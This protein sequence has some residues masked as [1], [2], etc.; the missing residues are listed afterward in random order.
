MP[1]PND[2]LYTLNLTIVALVALVAIV[3]L[4]AIVLHGK[5]TLNPAEPELQAADQVGSAVARSGSGGYLG[6]PVQQ[7]PASEECKKCLDTCQPTTATGSGSGGMMP[8]TTDYCTTC[9]KRCGSADA[10]GTGR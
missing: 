2:Q 10:S 9:L 5:G 8:P 1:K 4:T 3:G 6:P 7:P